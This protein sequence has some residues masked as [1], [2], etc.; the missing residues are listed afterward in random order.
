MNYSG[1]IKQAVDNQEV[2]DSLYRNKAGKT[3]QRTAEN[4]G[5]WTSSALLLAGL[6]AGAYGINE[7]TKS[8]SSRS[9]QLMS[10]LALGLGGTA[11]ARI[12]ADVIKHKGK[13]SPE[14]QAAYNE[15]S[16]LGN[17]LIPGMAIGNT[18]RSRETFKDLYM[19]QPDATKRKLDNAVF[20]YYGVEMP[21]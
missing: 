21:Q 15:G 4:W 8:F 11:A 2:L 16:T 6:L 12:V 13:R 18:Q 14:E 3:P 10:G 19:K 20:D 9:S 7:A 17:Y 5:P 1:L